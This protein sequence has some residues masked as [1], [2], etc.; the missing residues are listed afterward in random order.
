MFFIGVLVGMFGC[1]LIG[2]L[3][4]NKLELQKN[5]STQPKEVAEATENEEKGGENE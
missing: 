3:C 5:N 2:A 4:A 1:V